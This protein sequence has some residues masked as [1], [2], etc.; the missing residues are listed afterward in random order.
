MRGV[1]RVNEAALEV[2]SGPA[3][4]M[5]PRAQ[6]YLPGKII[7][8]LMGICQGRYLQS[9]MLAMSDEL[10]QDDRVTLWGLFFEAYEGIQ[11]RLDRELRDAVSLP[12]G[13]LEV[14]LRIGRTPGGAVPMTQL[15]EM[16]LFSSGG[17]SK[18]ADRMERAGLIHRVPCPTDRRSSLAS[19][20]PH[21]RAVLDRALAVH[22]PGIQR[23][24]VDKLDGEQRRQLEQILRTLR[25]G[26]THEPS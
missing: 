17:F 22:V 11:R 13:W 6:I 16:V 8:S 19:L 1:E 7:P 10:L 20:T 25:D 4:K 26:L 5:G 14:L 21:G 9:R 15:A 12:G 23:L 2:T 18:L 3:R 24:V